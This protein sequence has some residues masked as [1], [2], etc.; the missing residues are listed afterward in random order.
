MYDY[1]SMIKELEIAEFKKIKKC[2]FGD[3]QLKIFEEV[4]EKDR[5]VDSN[6]GMPEI[7]LQCTKQ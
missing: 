1:Q 3:S 4:E 2:N 6:N 7:C 5:F